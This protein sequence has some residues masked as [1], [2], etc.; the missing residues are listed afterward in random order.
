MTTPDIAA[1]M[2]E[3][4]ATED[5]RRQLASES[6]GLGALAELPQVPYGPGIGIAD[7]PLPV[8]GEGHQATPYTA[9]HKSYGPDRPQYADPAVGGVGYPY[10]AAQPALRHVSDIGDGRLLIEP[11]ADGGNGAVQVVS[12]GAAARRSLLG[13]LAAR[14]RRR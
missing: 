7:V 4:M 10:P 12:P 13:K 11:R 6:P 2:A 1:V 5:R 8:V 14:L 3:A 9:P